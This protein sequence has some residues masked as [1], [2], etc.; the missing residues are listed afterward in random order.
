MIETS[1]EKFVSS[2]SRDYP[3]K[4]VA[5]S[6]IVPCRDEKETIGVC[7][8]SILAQ[9]EPEGCFEVIVVDGMSVDGTTEILQEMATREPR[10]RIIRNP[11]RSTPAAFNLGIRRARG[12]YVALMGAHNSYAPDYLRQCLAVA[13][14]TGADNVGG[15]M[16]ARGETRL[17][18]AIALAHHSPFACGGARWH[19]PTY[20]GE[21]DT[22]FGGFYRREVLLQLG[23]F[24]ETLLRNQ[25]DELNLRLT[26]AGG[27]IWHSPRIR[28]WYHPRGDL[29]ALFRQYLQYGY[30]R[31]RVIR[32]H[33]LPG[34]WRQLAPGSF[35]LALFFLPVLGVFIKPFLWLWSTMIALYAIALLSTSLALA[36]HHGWHYLAF[37]P[38][39]F[40]AYHIGYGAGFLC[41]IFD[42]VLRRGP[43]D[44]V[45]LLTRTAKAQ[46]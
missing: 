39:V 27:R 1:E 16:I 34:S 24:D 18:H 30:W 14:E 20:E 21:A 2:D 15:S 17:Q 26:R 28:S 40:A 38:S 23:L 32:K 12:V 25:D 43:T 22:V 13:R 44:R 19:D 10:L 4:E 8:R 33:R 9:E 46:N 45:S 37:F 35:V 31:M 41:G 29:Q 5:V 42:W 6:V 7:L 3:S 36:L 11:L